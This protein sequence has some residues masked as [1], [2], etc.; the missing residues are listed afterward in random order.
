[1]FN[2]VWN[3]HWYINYCIFKIGAILY[4][5]VLPSTAI[6][7]KFNLSECSLLFVKICIHLPCPCLPCLGWTF[8]TKGFFCFLLCHSSPI[9]SIS[10][11]HIVTLVIRSASSLYCLSCYVQTYSSISFWCITVIFSTYISK[12]LSHQIAYIN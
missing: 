6:I 5:Y 11:T 2:F 1:M 7:N 10:S 9:Y 4:I 8:F 12:N 3:W